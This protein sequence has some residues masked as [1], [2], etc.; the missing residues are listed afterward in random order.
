M[1]YATLLSLTLWLGIE[2]VSGLWEMV[3]DLNARYD[4][5]RDGLNRAASLGVIFDLCER[6]WVRLYRCHE[7]YGDLEVVPRDDV[8][9]LL[10]KESSWDEPAASALSVRFETTD[11]GKVAYQR[12]TM[13]QPGDGT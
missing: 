11:A 12:L 4:A 3:W 1:R 8:Y 5:G 7:P 9:P 6:G 10:L 13:Q 2:D